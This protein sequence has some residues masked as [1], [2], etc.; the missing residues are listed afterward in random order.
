MPT[1]NPQKL[2]PEEEFLSEKIT[3]IQAVLSKHEDDDIFDSLQRLFQGLVVQED[4]TINFA[5]TNIPHESFLS[6]WIIAHTCR[7]LKRLNLSRKNLSTLPCNFA[8]LVALEHLDLSNNRFSEILP[9][10]CTLP[11]LSSLTISG[12]PLTINKIE[13]SSS[14]HLDARETNLETIPDGVHALTIYG[15]Q[16]QALLPVLAT[17]SVTSITIED[18]QRLSPYK[19]MLENIE[20]FIVRNALI[21]NL[22]PILNQC[23]NLSH[24]SWEHGHLVQWPDNIHIPKL[25]KLSLRHNRIAWLSGNL[26]R[27]TSL[28]I[29]DLS[30]NSL[31][32]IPQSVQ[33]CEQITTLSLSNCQI[34][35]I[36]A[37]LRNLT[38]LKSLDISGNPLK[39]L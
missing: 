5:R 38:N 33:A 34:T 7:N 11:S 30:H 3:E 17:S 15:Q 13:F 10:V 16:L 19:G 23:P 8:N 18:F 37:P 2:I 26:R 6:V 39:I 22:P 1:I 21:K 36:D 27:H 20:E 4:G 14:I 35:K 31:R 25:T 28:R 32:F 24:L 9:V 29:L 12:N